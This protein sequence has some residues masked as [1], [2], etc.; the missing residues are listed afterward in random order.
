MTM[1]QNSC[2]CVLL[3][4]CLC[5]NAQETA[6][7]RKRD[8]SA[9]QTQMAANN[10]KGAYSMLTQKVNINGAD[11][12]LSTQ[13]FKIYTD[14]HF[15][16]A[17]AIPGDSLADFGIGTYRIQGGKVI[18]YPFYTAQSGPVQDSFTLTINQAADGYAQ[19]F[20]LP[21]DSQGR[22]YTLIEDYRNA[23][24]NVRSPL[25]GAWRMTRQTYY[26]AGGN[27]VMASNL[28][29]YKVYE[30]GHFIWASSSIDSATQR[31]VAAFG[32]GTFKMKGPNKAV[33]TNT[34]STYRT[35]LEGTPVTLQLVFTG[36]D[37]YQQ[38]ITGPDGGR[39]VEEYER[40]K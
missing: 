10:M 2:L 11:S 40:L 39:Q 21:P 29:Q 26:P 37:H 17:H 25:D 13:Q 30:S 18:E 1:I 8:K 32:Y 22:Q 28:V 19:T 35:M 12:I 24:R 34:Q 20:N 36:K 31:R 6:Q 38:T 16:Y 15:M 23:G 9:G 14:R 3:A 7:T 4:L 5:A 33:E 27:P